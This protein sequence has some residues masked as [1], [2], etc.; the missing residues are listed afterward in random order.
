MTEERAAR[1]PQGT[2]SAE[3]DQEY[4]A[5]L[6]L[7]VR[8]ELGLHARPAGQLAKEAQ[9]FMAQVWVLVDDRQADAKSVLDI[10]SLAVGQGQRVRLKAHGPD[11]H[12]AVD[13]LSDLF[14]NLFG[15]AK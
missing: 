8:N 7:R 3:G 5:D 11:A 15:E 9:K 13:H 1:A 4:T 12:D 6:A 2:E 10:L 14:H